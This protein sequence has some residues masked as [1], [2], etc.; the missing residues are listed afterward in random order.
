MADEQDV[1]LPIESLRRL[2]RIVL[3]EEGLPSETEV[4][5]LFVGDRVMAEYNRRFLRR[6]GPTD[7]L[8]LPLVPPEEG[9]GATIGV[10]TP[11]PVPHGLGDVFIA[12]DYVRRQARERGSDFGKEMSLM[13]T[14][15]LLHL[16]GYD[17]QSPDEAEVMEDRER[18][19]LA[20]VG[21]ERP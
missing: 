5:I 4:G 13:V 9:R 10:G 12:P 8:A 2:A 17:H 15:G 21:I 19:L 6:S 11:D 14:H 16:V 7:V 3:G 1:P 20:Q 18:A